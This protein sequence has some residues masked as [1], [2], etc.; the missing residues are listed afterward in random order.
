MKNGDGDV[1]RDIQRR[2]PKKRENTERG[3]TTRS[4][5][6]GAAGEGEEEGVSLRSTH[7]VRWIYVGVVPLE[8]FFVMLMLVFT[9]PIVT[10]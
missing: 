4:S 9:L 1:R 8:L 2:T 5:D 7:Y 3:R 10:L 6:R